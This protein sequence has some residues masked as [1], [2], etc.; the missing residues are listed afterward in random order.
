M[1]IFNKVL[2]SCAMYCHRE[3]VKIFKCYLIP[4][5]SYG[6]LSKGAIFFDQPCRYLG[7]LEGSS[8]LIEQPN[9]FC[10]SSENLKKAGHA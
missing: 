6:T 3:M 10:T 1:E 7:G 2:H 8:R 5:K 4:K 9:C